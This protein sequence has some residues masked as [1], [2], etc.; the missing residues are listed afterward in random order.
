MVPNKG[1]R[2]KAI[3]FALLLYS[4]LIGLA[5]TICFITAIFFVIPKEDLP[6]LIEPLVIMAVFLY[7][8]CA[9][10]LFIRSRFFNK[11]RIKNE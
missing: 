1:E 6:Y 3:R 7:G 2:K 11:E 10:A 8:T 4:I 9:I 5:S